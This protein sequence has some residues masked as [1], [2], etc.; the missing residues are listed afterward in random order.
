MNT[1]VTVKY[2]SGSGRYFIQAVQQTAGDIPLPAPDAIHVRVPNAWHETL[3]EN[4]NYYYDF[5]TTKLPAQTQPEL[6][7][8]INLPD[9]LTM[10]FSVL[11]NRAKE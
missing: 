4:V 7:T 10:Q 1:F 9:N 8:I 5:D 3:F 2:D 6:G 11:T